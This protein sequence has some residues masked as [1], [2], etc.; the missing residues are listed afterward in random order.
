MRRRARLW[1]WVVS[2]PRAF[3][4]SGPNRPSLV[5]VLRHPRGERERERA[6][7]GERGRERGISSTN[8]PSRFNRTARST[9]F[10]SSAF[11]RPARHPGKDHVPTSS[12]QRTHHK[13]PVYSILP[14]LFPLLFLSFFFFLRTC[15]Q[16]EM[17]YTI[18][19]GRIPLLICKKH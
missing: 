7:D 14:F 15:D 5:G 3:A 2:G 12:S 6:G 18:A 8:R 10:T 11:P 17:F 16:C 4:S 1:V 13:V 19:R 9:F